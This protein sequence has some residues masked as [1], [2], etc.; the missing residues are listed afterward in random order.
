MTAMPIVR[1]GVVQIPGVPFDAHAT[2]AEPN[3]F[4][5]VV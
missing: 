1:A 2:L 5:A 4:A 3:N